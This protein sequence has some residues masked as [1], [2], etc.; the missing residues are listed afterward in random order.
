MYRTAQIH[1]RVN[2]TFSY[3]FLVLVQL[4][5]GSVLSP[6]LFVIALSI[7]SIYQ[8]LSKEIRLVGPNNEEKD[9]LVMTWHY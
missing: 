2:G 3:D 4:D 9:L 5:Q 6:L 7:T 1:G 8:I